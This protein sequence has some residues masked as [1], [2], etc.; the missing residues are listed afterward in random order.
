MLH[1]IVYETVSTIYVFY[2]RGCTFSCSITVVEPHLLSHSHTRSPSALFRFLWCFFRYFMYSRPPN[3]NS[4]RSCHTCDSVV[5]PHQTRAVE[6]Y[7]MHYSPKIS[8]DFI[9]STITI[10]WRRL[11]K[12]ARR[13][14]DHRE[15]CLLST[16]RQTAMIYWWWCLVEESNVNTRL[17]YWSIHPGGITLLATPYTAIR[18]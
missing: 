13:V 2:R 7:F 15:N 1:Y 12:F 18:R 11:P 6:K 8:F 17:H 10:T 5:K 9:V 3:R 4:L 14:M 16:G